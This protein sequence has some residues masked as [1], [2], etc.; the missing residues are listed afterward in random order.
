MLHP[1]WSGRRAFTLIEL[2]VVIAIIAI[3]IGL[4]IPAVQ[5]VRESA[6]RAKCA[7]HMKQLALACH[8]HHDAVGRLPPAVMLAGITDPSGPQPAD[9][10]SSYRTPGFGPNWAVMLLPYI[11]QGPLFD[12]V[13]GDVTA[14]VSSN[15]TN[16]NWRKI[17]GTTIPVLLCGS[18]DGGRTP[19]A[20]NGGGWARGNYAANA[21][22]GW[23]NWTAMGQSKDGGSGGGAFTNDVG[24]MFGMNWGAKIPADV[25]DG[26]STTIM[27]NEVR[28]GLTENDRRGVWAMGLAGSS[29]TAAHSIGDAT[30]PN[31]DGDKSDDI[32]NCTDVKNA[33][34]G[35]SI[36]QRDRMGCSEDNAPN[37]WPNWQA[38]A[39]SRHPGGLQAAMAD[40]SVRFIQNAVTQ[41]AWRRANSRN[42]GQTYSVD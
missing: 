6:A 32:E 37:N 28:I 30:L 9:I 36:A 26:T 34:A 17:R 35:V 8:V 2:L 21:G 11:E 3:L 38:Q 31:D 41:D 23:F 33:F 5:K 16:Q 20:L 15:G 40:G 29:V 18:D 39:R 27:L 12:Q 42:D 1:H 13:S 7:N 24:G 25:P 14:F 22:P 4:L 10:T 19:F